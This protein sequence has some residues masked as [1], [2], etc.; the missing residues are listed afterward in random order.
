MGSGILA[1]A[2]RTA[3]AVV[4]IAAVSDPAPTGAATLAPH[5]R[6]P[7]V[8]HVILIVFEN[9]ERD[10]VIGNRDA[11][12]FN[13]LAS[14]YAQALHYQA[15][16]HPSFPNYLALI[17]G[18]THGMKTDCI[19]PAVCPQ[20]GPTIGAQLTRL[21]RSWGA[22]AEGYPR[23]ESFDPKHV[24][25][26]YFRDTARKVRPLSALRPTA[27]PTFAFVTP[28]RCHDMHDCP[29]STGDAWLARFVKPLLRQP[30]TL[31]IIVFD[32]GTSDT[33]GGGIVPLI[34]AGSA[35]RPHTTIV[36]SI[37]HYSLLRTVEAALGLPPLGNAA[38]VSAIAGIWRR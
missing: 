26:L 34:L 9:H 7:R 30:S 15:L 32:E 36:P 14:R 33:G 38:H 31:V 37:N 22:Y 25:F 8:S 27:L 12:T 28:N 2:W 10:A 35:V 16:T 19:D 29:V 3:L 11:P 23:A 24:P 13:A 4:L 5:P 6:I 17:S 18:S 21:G 1:R 20:T